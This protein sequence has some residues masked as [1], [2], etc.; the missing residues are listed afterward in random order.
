M[1][2]VPDQRHFPRLSTPNH[3]ISTGGFRLRRVGGGYCR[4]RSNRSRRYCRASPRAGRRR[5]SPLV[6]TQR[7]SRSGVR[8]LDTRAPMP[9]VWQR[10]PNAVKVYWLE[11]ELLNRTSL[12]T[13]TRPAPRYST[14]S[15]GSTT[16]SEGTPP[17]ATTHLPATKGAH[18]PPKA[19]LKRRKRTGGACS[20]LPLFDTGV[21]QSTLLVRGPAPSRDM[22]IVQDA[23]GPAMRVF[24]T[25]P[26][27]DSGHQA[28]AA[29][30]QRARGG[31]FRET[32]TEASPL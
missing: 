22:R 9:A 17:S 1:A 14:T 18:P 26:T 25:Q 8:E 2:I 6:G 30:V 31:T 20:Y 21:A 27:N 13:R 24:P 5:S 10:I 3:R 4:H 11:T 16:P 15:K 28:S 19:T 12:R 29:P 7:Q 23:R 32:W